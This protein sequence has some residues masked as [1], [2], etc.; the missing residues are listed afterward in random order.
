MNQGVLEDVHDDCDLAAY[1]S[2][3]RVL[4]CE[5]R[6][7]CPDA[8]HGTL[9]ASTLRSVPDMVTASAAETEM[10]RAEP[11]KPRHHHTIGLATFPAG[12][13]DTSFG[14]F[15]ELRGDVRHLGPSPSISPLM[16]A[17]KLN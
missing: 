9:Q 5:R 13:A 8:D 4:S 16:M 10:R 17:K 14:L 15:V 7:Y 11:V 2:D 3:K 12:L 1:S 6:S